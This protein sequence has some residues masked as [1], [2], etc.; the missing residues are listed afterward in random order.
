MQKQPRR[1]LLPDLCV[2]GKSLRPVFGKVAYSI[3]KGGRLG[4][5]LV[6]CEVFMYCIFSAL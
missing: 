5:N 6:R 4:L 3:S 1:A 2:S